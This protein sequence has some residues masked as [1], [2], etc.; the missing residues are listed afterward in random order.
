MEHW[1]PLFYDD[2]ETAFDYLKGFRLVTDHTVREAA[3]ER[4]TLVSDYYEA[5]RDNGSPVKG[6]ASQAVPY[7]PVPPGQLYLDGATFSAALDAAGAIRLGSDEQPS[8]LQS[9]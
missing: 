3:N 4:S 6:A 8:K 5:R 1:L 9:L 7:K 2:L